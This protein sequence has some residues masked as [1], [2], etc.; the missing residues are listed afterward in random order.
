MLLRVSKC[1][2]QREVR[3]ILDLEKNLENAEE[4]VLLGMADV[5]SS[6]STSFLV[7]RGR[8][9]LIFRLGQFER[10]LAGSLG[11]SH[12]RRNKCSVFMQCETN[13]GW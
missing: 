2:R 3:D 13:V 6:P 4:L 9:S 11:S 5:A 10:R 8:S 7:L 1:A 12:I